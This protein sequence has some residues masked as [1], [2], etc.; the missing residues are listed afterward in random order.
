MR[1]AL[2]DFVLHRRMLQSVLGQQSQPKAA[3]AKRAHQP[4]MDEAYPESEYNLN[5]GAASTGLCM[6]VC[7][8]V[9][10]RAAAVKHR[11]CWWKACHCLCMPMREFRV[12]PGE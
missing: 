9:C 4:V 11:R 10:A 2:G 7:V 1:H 12:M 8:C 3:G 6:N 5:P